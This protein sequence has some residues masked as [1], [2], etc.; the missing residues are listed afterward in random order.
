VNPGDATIC[1]A[2]EQEFCAEVTGGVGPFTYSWTKD[3][4]PF[5][6]DV[7]CITVSA[8]GVY[9]VTVVD[10]STKC[11]A[12][13]CATL[14]VVPTPEC[15]ITGPESLCETDVNTPITYC[16]DVNDAD[17]YLWEII[18]GPATI[19][20][21]DDGICV[22]IIPSDLGTI[23][24]KLSLFNDVAGDDANCWNSCEITINVE[25]CGKTFCSFTQGA[26]GNAGGKDC[27][28]M[29]TTEVISA[30]LKLGGPVVVGVP[31]NSITLNSAACIIERL[32]AGGTPMALDLGQD[33]TDDCGGSATKLLNDILKKGN[34]GGRP[35]NNVLIGQVVTLTLNVRLG[36]LPCL[37]P[38]EPDQLLGTFELPDKPFCTVPYDDPNACAKTVEI[39]EALQGMTVADLLEAAN[40]ALGGDDTYS[41][42]DIYK[43][44]TAL[45]EG[46]DECRTIVPCIR[47]EIC[48]N[49]CDDDD[50][51]LTDLDD[52]D[53]QS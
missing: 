40:A 3:G 29:D 12:N 1:D 39:P 45:N 21:A 25:E 50:D 33:V 11:D 27:R 49:G 23:V 17:G 20:G 5:A 36:A 9:C 47:P 4:S 13:D 22:D 26:W 6:G 43:A 38:N 10:Q 35:Y 31:G 46:F 41:I 44:V 7:N 52:P 51:G 48:G 14:A 18:S 15:G 32:P 28:G 42:S 24:L 8:A 19:D 34:K 16:S 37:D 2:N 53:C 30:L